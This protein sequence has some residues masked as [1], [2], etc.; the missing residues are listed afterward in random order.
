MR[1]VLAA[2]LVASAVLAAVGEPGTHAAD[3]DAA[4]GRLEAAGRSIPFSSR[5]PGDVIV[6]VY[7]GGAGPFRFL[8]DT[9]STHTAVTEAL[10]ATLHLEPVART[11]IATSVGSVPCLVARMD[12]VALGSAHVAQLLPTVL[13]AGGR[14]A[15]DDGL[16][17]IIGQDFLSSFDYTIDY[18]RHLLLWDDGT[19]EAAGVQLRLE[20]S[21]GRFVV[22]LP[23]DTGGRS[24]RLVPDSGADGVVLFDREQGLGIVV[25]QTTSAYRIASVAG[26]AGGRA[27]LVDDLRVGAAH[28]QRQ[29]AALVPAPAG[30]DGSDGLLPLALFG[31][32]SIDNTRRYMSV[33]LP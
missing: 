20:R 19:R 29:P 14:T 1:R 9:G 17:G 21:N 18:R 31:R 15:L 3:P 26:A 33:E 8:L 16:D 7:I 27:V 25:R 24:L 6:P 23:Q 10:R 22:D 32:V 28:L 5:R 2:S 4:A 30:A 12:A 13:P 11:L